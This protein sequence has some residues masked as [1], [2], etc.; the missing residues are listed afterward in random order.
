MRGAATEAGAG[1]S[2][3]EAIAEGGGGRAGATWSSR[4]TSLRVLRV[5]VQYC[6][7]TLHD[8]G[9]RYAGLQYIIMCHLK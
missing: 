5:T 9:S 2:E 8:F 4:H 7:V 1:S 6:T 3:V